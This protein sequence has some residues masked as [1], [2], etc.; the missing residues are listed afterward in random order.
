[1]D[2]ISVS[3]RHC[4]HADRVLAALLIFLPFRQFFILKN[5]KPAEKVKRKH[6]ELHILLPYRWSEISF[7]GDFSFGKSQKFQ[8]TKSGM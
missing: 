5:F 2:G 7:K 8:G 4:F 3:C 1:M 6:N